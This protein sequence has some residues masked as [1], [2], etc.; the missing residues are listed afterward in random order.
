MATAN[1]KGADFQVGAVK[2]LFQTRAVLG[3]RYPYGVSSDGQRF[4]INT[5][6][7]QSA[8]SPIAVVLNW[9]A[10]LKK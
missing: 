1:G 8:S 9:T 7:E 10:G 6:P 2:T 3:L 4:L 5:Q